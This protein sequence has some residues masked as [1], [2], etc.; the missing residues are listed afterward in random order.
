MLLC[1]ILYKLDSKLDAIINENGGPKTIQ[2]RNAIKQSVS[3]NNINLSLNFL[4]SVDLYVGERLHGVLFSACVSTPFFGLAYQP[5]TLD[6][7]DSINL[8]EFCEKVDRIE[9]FSLFDKINEIYKDK[10]SVQ[11]LIF[12]NMKLATT[13]QSREIEKIKKILSL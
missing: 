5:K 6:F 3:I 1:I 13:I 9:L 4:E 11:N 8:T 7:L 2:H 12:N 10:I